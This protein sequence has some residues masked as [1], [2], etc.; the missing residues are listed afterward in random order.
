MGQCLA[1]WMLKVITEQ[2]TVGVLRRRA[3]GVSM[4]GTAQPALEITVAVAAGLG[5]DWGR[6]GVFVASESWMRSS[7]Q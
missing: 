4:V 2:N 1:G 5:P 6:F 7:W 3:P